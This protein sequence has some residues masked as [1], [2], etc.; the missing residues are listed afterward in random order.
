MLWLTCGMWFAAVALGVH[1][2]GGLWDDAMQRFVAAP[3]ARALTLGIDAAVIGRWL[4]IWGWLCVANLL[5]VG[6][7]LQMLPVAIALF[8]LLLLT[9]RFALSFVVRR[10]QSLL[11]D[12]MV[13]CAQAMANSARAG[14]SLEQGLAAASR[15]TPQPLATELQRMMGEYDHGRPLGQALRDAKQRLQLDSFS[16][17]ASAVIVSLERGGRVTQSLETISRSLQENQRVERKLAADTA[18]GWKV[19]LILTAFPFLFLGG[20]MIL[21]PTGTQLMFSTLLGQFLLLII[22]ALVVVSLWWSRRILTIDL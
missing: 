17:F 8:G 15:Q 12:Q 11:R 1:A 21:H 10:R 6:V 19:V 9:P 22:L 5:I 4:R 3:R 20:F 18:S 16:L 7:W 14:Q 13:G 2:V